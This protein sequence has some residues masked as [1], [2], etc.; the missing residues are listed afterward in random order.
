MPL[1]MKHLRTNPDHTI[2]LIADKALP[3]TQ[4]FAGDL[5]DDFYN[6]FSK[7]KYLLID[8]ELVI[9]AAWSEANGE[10]IE[11]PADIPH[12]ELLLAAGV[13]SIRELQ[14]IED[15]TTLSGIGEV[16]AGEINEYLINQP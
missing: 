12:R 5:P 10:L 8:G 6:T 1:N 3:D 7:G 4:P 11:L 9:N 2:H 14:D 13:S 16:K 15:L